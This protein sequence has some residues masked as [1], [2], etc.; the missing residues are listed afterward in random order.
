MSSKDFNYTNTTLPN[1]SDT[2]E[3]R[4]GIVVSEWNSHIT[5]DLLNA[6]V[7][8]LLAEGV[9][10][11]N[12]SVRRVPGSFELIHGCSQLAH[13]GFVDAIIALG[14]VVRGDTP[15]FDYICMGATM[16]LT[17]LNREG[18]V[19]VINGILTTNTMEQALERTQGSLG[20]KG[21]EFAIS[22]IKMVDYVWE[23]VK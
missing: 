7:E 12:I 2:S 8:T 3:M 21:R 23:L 13:F 5:D 16:G 15:H 10:E 17:E 9:Q 19:P 4:I 22:A 20:N 1:N 11:S 6:A 18:K 14:C